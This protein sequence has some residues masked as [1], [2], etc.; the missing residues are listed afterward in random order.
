ML[1]GSEGQVLCSADI[2]LCASRSGP[3]RHRLCSGPVPDPDGELLQAGRDV[4]RRQDLLLL[5]SDELLWRWCPGCRSRRSGSGCEGSSSAAE[6]RSRSGS[7]G[8]IASWTTRCADQEIEL[9]SRRSTRFFYAW[10]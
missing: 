7:E 5:G 3:V 9:T 1:Q 2:L 4:L 8:L 6:G 10:A